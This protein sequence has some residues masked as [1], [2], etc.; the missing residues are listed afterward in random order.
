MLHCL[1]VYGYVRSSNLDIWGKYTLINDPAVKIT[2]AGGEH[3]IETLLTKSYLTE[4]TNIHEWGNV[5]ARSL[6][7][8]ADLQNTMEQINQFQRG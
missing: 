8:M 5:L 3:T 6:L 2:F 4:F 1:L 7:F